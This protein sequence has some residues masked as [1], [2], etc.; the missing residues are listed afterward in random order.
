MYGP[1]QPMYGP[2]QAESPPWWPGGPAPP[3]QAVPRV[4]E[5]RGSTARHTLL[6]RRG[7]SSSAGG[8]SRGE[9][10]ARR[11]AAGIA[12]L[13]GRKG[14]G[15]QGEREGNAAMRGAFPLPLPGASKETAA[16]WRGLTAPWRTPRPRGPPDLVVGAVDG[17]AMLGRR[18]TG[19]PLRSGKHVP[20]I[21]RPWQVVPQETATAIVCP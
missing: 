12:C 2:C 17:K 20:P 21:L 11:S 5:G 10:A 7:A 13:A 16:D 19:T 14:E 18:L 9:D 15:V 3:E 1:C 4:R 6:V 8:T